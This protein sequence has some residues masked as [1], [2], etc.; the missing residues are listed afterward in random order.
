[1]DIL[2]Q[3]IANAVIAGSLYALVAL[4]FN[5]IFGAVR[6][7]DLGFGAL[8]VVGGYAMFFCATTL[9]MHTVWA[10]PLG[11]LVAGLVGLVVEKTVYQKLRVKKASSMVLLVASL[12]V[13]TLLQALIAIF[14]SSQFQVPP[15][16]LFPHSVVS[17]AGAVMTPVQLAILGSTLAVMLGLGFL[18]HKTLFGKAVRA[19]RDDENVASIV[20]INTKKIIGRVFFLGSALAGFAGIMAGLDTGLEPTMGFS[21]L[22]KGVIAC[23]IGGVG[24]VFG[25]VMGAFL[26]GFVENFGVWYVSGEWKDAIAFTLLILFLLFRPQGIFAKK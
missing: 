12:G 5:L 7:F 20:G 8:T 6:F 1:M 10:I 11:V 16:D 24:S 9:G 22:L 18:L 4:G 21:L 2:P 19:I 26:L 25:G 14:F 3:I 23:I 17:F 13:F 15:N